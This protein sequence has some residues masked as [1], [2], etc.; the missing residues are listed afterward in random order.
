MRSREL[1]TRSLEFNRP[2]RIPRLMGL[3]PWATTHFGAAVKRIQERFPDDIIGCPYFCKPVQGIGDPYG[4]GSYV[5]EWGCT[6]VNR[7]ARNIGANFIVSVI[8]HIVSDMPSIWEKRSMTCNKNMI[9]IF[10]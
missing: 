8:P 1:V 3:L 5:D 6:F 4:L 2:K 9:N 10:I 7:Q